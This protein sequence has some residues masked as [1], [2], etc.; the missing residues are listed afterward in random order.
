MTRFEYVPDSDDQLVIIDDSRPY[1]V[2]YYLNDRF[3]LYGESIPDEYRNQR[4]K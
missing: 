2:Y 3:V 1:W 4:D